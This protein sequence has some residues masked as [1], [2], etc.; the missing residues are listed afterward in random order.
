MELTRYAVALL[1]LERKLAQRPELLT[2]LR[3]GIEDVLRNLPHFPVDHGNTIARFANL[4][5]NSL[6]TLTP[7]IMVSGDPTHLNNPDNANRIRALLLAGVRAAI[8]W[9]QSGGSRL[10]LLLRR[11]PL[12]RE[13]RRLLASLD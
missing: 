7:R 8:L 12:L 5:L 9:R 3:D 1:G 13:T 11:N 6:S 2:M 10:T 4:Y